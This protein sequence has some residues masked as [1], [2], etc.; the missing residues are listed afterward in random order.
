MKIQIGTNIYTLQNLLVNPKVELL[1][2]AIRENLTG[3]ITTSSG[4]VF[5]YSYDPITQT[6]DFTIPG[7]I[8][9]NNIT[10]IIEYSLVSSIVIDR[11]IIYEIV[12]NERYFI[13]TEAL[14]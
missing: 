8:I 10:I 11:G 5:E 7:N 6:Y 1:S 14:R 9:N 2:N 4:A 13:Y 3:T 12:G